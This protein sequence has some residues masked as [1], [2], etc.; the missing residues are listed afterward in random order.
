MTTFVVSSRLM[1]RWSPRWTWRLT[2]VVIVTD[3]DGVVP[4]CSSD[5]TYSTTSDAAEAT[6]TAACDWKVACC[7]AVLLAGVSKTSK[8]WKLP[9]MY[10]RLHIQNLSGGES[11]TPFIPYSTKILSRPSLFYPL[12]SSICLFLASCTYFIGSSTGFLCPDAKP[13]LLS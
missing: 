12:L 4:S 8:W 3:D 7:D 11:T 9:L 2:D 1:L 6:A 5:A 13:S 10:H